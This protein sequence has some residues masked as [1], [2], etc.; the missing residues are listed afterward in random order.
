MNSTVLPSLSTTRVVILAC[1]PNYDI[2]FI[3]SIRSAGEL[4]M[5]TNTLINLGRVSLDP[6]PDSRVVHFEATLVHHLFQIAVGELVSAI[7]SDTQKNNRRLKVPPFKGGHILLHK[8][9][10]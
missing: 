2:G 5:G 4:Q 6:S 7:P 9:D 1:L 8:Y 3:Y 10:S